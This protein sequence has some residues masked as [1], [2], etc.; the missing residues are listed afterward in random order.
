[1]NTLEEF[2]LWLSM[3][4]RIFSV[5]SIRGEKE[6]LEQKF[7]E[8]IARALGVPVE[9]IREDITERWVKNFMKAFIKPEFWKIYGL[10]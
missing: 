2:L 9:H 4:P 10:E 7:K 6:V 1:M 3:R 8:G 5:K